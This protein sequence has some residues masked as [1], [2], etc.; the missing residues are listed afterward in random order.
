M[1]PNCM[2]YRMQ[3][4]LGVGRTNTAQPMN[5]YQFFSHVISLTCIVAVIE[6]SLTWVICRAGRQPKTSRWP[7]I[8]SA[9][10]ITLAAA[11]ILV[12]GL[13]MSA[14]YK[15]AA[16][17]N[18]L[19]S[20]P[21]YEIVGREHNSWLVRRQDTGET[22]RIWYGGANVPAW[23]APGGTFTAADYRLSFGHR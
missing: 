19:T 10:L 6:L 21:S 22:R 4:H 23:L 18:F 7:R 13:M 3:Y 15:S 16:A 17:Y 1:D 2:H 9:P 14:A 20:G 5:N 8:V 11:V 12:W